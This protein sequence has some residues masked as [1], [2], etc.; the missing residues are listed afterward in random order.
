MEQDST[1]KWFIAQLKPN[2]AR[3]AERNLTR[4]GFA[5]FQPT[6]EVTQ[7]RAGRFM[8]VR[9]PLFPGYVFVPLNP[10]A[11]QW[12]AVNSTYG[13]SRLV[14]LGGYPAPVPDGLIA[15]LRRRCDPVGRVLPQETLEAGDPVRVTEGPFAD[16]VGRV[17]AA[18]PDHR[19]WVLLDLLGGT[20]RVSLDPKQ[21]KRA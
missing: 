15:E 16:L 3:I 5:I 13:I 7:R 2:C 19:I 14:R 18:A 12:R 17:L 20:I 21:L 8:Q 11:G 4:Q 9:Q 10:V 6:E 1:T